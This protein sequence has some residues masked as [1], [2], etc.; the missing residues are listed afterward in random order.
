MA[1][2]SIIIDTKID[3]DGLKKGFEQ[4]KTESGS[5]ANVA[6]KSVQKINESFSGVDVS[7]AAAAL[8]TQIAQM[9]GQMQNIQNQYKQAL[10]ND[11]DKGASQLGAKY[12]AIYDKIAVARAKLAVEVEQ[13][14]QKQAKAEEK[15]AQRESQAAEKRAAAEERASERRIS[16]MTKGLGRFGARFREILA[17]A[18]VFNVISAGLRSLTS[19]YGTALKAN[20]TFSSALA[21]LQ[22]TFFT[23]FQPI[24]EVA[25]PALTALMRILTAVIQV[26]GRFFAAITGKSYGQMSKNAAALNDEAEAIGGVGSAARE[27]RKELAGFDEINRLEGSDPGSGGG[28]GS[29]GGEIAPDFETMD[30]DQKLQDILK[31]VTGIGVALL[32][33]KI[34]SAFTN[35]LSKTLGIAMAIGGAVVFV[36]YFID[37]WNNGIDWNNLN[38]LIVSATIVV[39]GLG[40]AFGLTAAAIGLLVIGVALI[41]LAFQ[42]WIKTGELS[43]EAFAALAIGILAVGAAFSLL[44]GSWIPLVI[45]AIVGFVVACI[46]KGDEIKAIFQKIDDW[47]QG[48][49]TKDWTEV[50]G[51]VLGGILNEFFDIVEVVWDSIREIFEGIVDFVGGVFSGDWDRAFDGLKSIAKGFQTFIDGVFNKIKEWILMPFDNWLS[52]IF[53]TDFSENFGVLGE[54]LDGFFDGVKIIWEGIKRILEGIITFIDGVFSGSWEKAWEGIKEIFGGIWD[55]LVGLIKAPINAIIGLINGLVS[56][57]TN[58][59]NGAINALNSIKVNVPSWIPVIGGKSFG[60][61]IPTLAAPQI[62]YLA[63]GAVIPPNEPFMAVLGDQRR[64]TNIEAPLETIQE[65]VAIVMQDMAAANLAGFEETIGVLR[66]ILEAIYGIQIGDDVIGRAVARYNRKLAVQRG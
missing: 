49:F 48:V 4:L 11:D 6:N 61:N 25:I 45:A 36:Q 29:A 24:Y 3:T 50:F 8:R 34:T 16:S 19:H 15:A 22:G 26:I 46:T 52:G 12:E 39:I 28:G 63:K 59:I 44:T 51:P 66:E 54:V 30:I 13:A 43:N 65:A 41:V 31:W 7:K 56:G 38:G 58:G 53:S 47:L 35:S 10:A 40:L 64:G 55:A 1:D 27:A 23:A 57:I 60:F 33:W 37:A 5:V 42:E 62:P 21:Q 9:E 18:L 2:G 20:S 14:A 32:A 17:G